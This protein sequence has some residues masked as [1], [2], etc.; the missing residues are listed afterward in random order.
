M[1]KFLLPLLFLVATTAR[2]QVTPRKASQ[3]RPVALGPYRLAV[4]THG[5]VFLSGITGQDPQTK[6]LVAGGV[7]AETHRAL[8]SIQ[9]LLGE[10][11]LT[12]Q[13]VVTATVYLKDM[14]QYAVL[15]RVY[16]QYFTRDFPARTCIA[17]ADLPNG[18]NVEITVTAA[19]RP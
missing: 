6:Q 16:Q 9:I 10:R 5:F 19:A 14:G 17:V 11:A 2:A 4:A 3:H 7:E 13:D 1:N 18:A 8:R 15:N 12:L